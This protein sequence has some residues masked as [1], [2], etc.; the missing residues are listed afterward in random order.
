MAS[1]PSKAKGSLAK[2]KDEA[3]S[4]PMIHLTHEHMKKFG[5][6][7]M[8][9]VGSKIKISG[10]VHV[11][12]TSEHD[13]SHSFGEPGAEGEGPSHSMTLHLHKMAMA[14][15]GIPEGEKE[16]SQKDGMK[17]AVDAAL[18][19]HAGSESA[20][21]KAKGKTPTPRGGGD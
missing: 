3:F 15:D 1:E 16:E 12:S 18:A 13:G 9:K 19:K 5:I 20:K 2:D 10:L 11:G 4:P 17:S 21:G 14:H 7:Q 8:P 6:K